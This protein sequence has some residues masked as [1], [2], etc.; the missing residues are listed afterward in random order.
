[1]KA[2]WKHAKFTS[3]PTEETRLNVI[4]VL[5]GSLSAAFNDAAELIVQPFVQF[6]TISLVHIFLLSSPSWIFS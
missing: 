1:M 5:K 2:T 6:I 3:G 4:N